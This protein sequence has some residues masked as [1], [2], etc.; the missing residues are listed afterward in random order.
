MKKTFLSIVLAAAWLGAA[1]AEVPAPSTTICGIMVSNDEW[2]S[3]ARAGVYSVEVRP[4]GAVKPV[5]T[6]AQMAQVAAAVR[7][8]NLM[9]CVE[10][11]A[12]GTFY[13]SKYS[14]NSWN[15]NG[16][17]QEIDVVNVPSD[18]CFDPVTGRA[19]GGFWDA[20]YLGYSRFGSF[21]LITA[22][23]TDINEVQRDERDIFA[24]AADGRGTIYCLFGAYDYLATLD[25]KT[26][27]VE[28]IKTTGLKPETRLSE[29]RL[30]S[31]CYDAENDRL[32]AVV[33][34]A[35]HNVYTSALYTIDPHT[36]EVTKVMDMPGNACMAGIYVLEGAVPAEAPAEPTGLRVEPTAGLNGRV[37]FTAPT[38]TVG[39]SELSGT[40]M[41]IVSVNGAE[42][43]IE[44]IAPGQEVSRELT[45]AEG[46]N[47]VKVTM[48]SDVQRGGSATVKAWIGEDT[49]AGVRDLSLTVADGR[50]TLTWKA[51]LTGVHGAALDPAA[52]RYRIVRNSDGAVVAESFPGLSF[53]DTSVPAGTKALS[54]TVTAFNSKGESEPVRSNTALASGALSVPFSE[55][56]DTEDDFGLWTVRDLNGGATWF[57][58]PGDNIVPDPCATYK[59]DSDKLPADEWL[60]SPAIQLKAGETYRLGYDWRVYNSRYKE[61]FS[62]A[63][64][65][66]PTPESMTRILSAQEN[67]TNVKFESAA[68]AFTVETD[69]IYYLGIHETSAAYQ[70]QLYLDNV[71]ISAMDAGVPAAIADLKAEPA[72]QGARR[73]TLGFTAPDKT[74]K[75][76]PLSGSLTYSV[77]RDGVAVAT[78]VSVQPGQPVSLTDEAIEKDGPVSYTAWCENESGAG[79]AVTV[80][81]YCGVDAPGAVTG[82]TLTEMN[83]HPHL[84]W[85]EP[86]A[87]ANN[88]WFDRSQLT[89]RIVRSDGT[90]VAEK[91]VG[92]SYTDESFTSPASGQEG[93]WYL[94][95]PYCGSTKGVYAQTELMLFGQPYK[96][97]VTE[98]FA[99]AS[100]ALNPWSAQS[101]TAVNYSWT[102]DNM[103][104]NPQAPDQNG[105]RGLAT[106]HSVGEPVGSTAYFYSPM[107]DISALDAPEVSF[108]LYHAPGEGNET[109]DFLVSAGTDA[110]VQLED[111]PTVR[112]D[113]ESGWVR[114]AFDLSA[115]KSAPW[116]RIGFM[117]TADKKADFYLD[118]FAIAEAVATDAALTSLSGPARIAAGETARY[119][120]VVL[121]AGRRE[122]P[123]VKISLTDAAGTELAHA[124]TGAIPAG[125]EARLTLEVPA[126]ETGTLNVTASVSAE[127]DANPA[128]DRASCVTQVVTPAVAA[129]TDVAAIR[130]DDG[131]EITWADV[132]A[133]GVVTDDVES[134][135]PWAIDGIGEWS[136]WDGDYDLTYQINFQG[137][138]YPHATD[139]KAFQVCD[140]REMGITIWPE[141]EPHSGDNM[142]MAMCSQIYVNND[143]L[144]SPELNGR[145]Q[146]ISFFARSFTLQDTPAERMRVWYSTTDNDPANFTEITANY[147]ELP[148]NWTEYRYF[149]PEGARH[150]AVNCVSD[151]AFAMFVDD[152]TF[153]DLSVP[154][155]ELTGYEV[156]RDGQRIGS[157]DG[158]SF[159]DTEAPAEAASY[160]VKAVYDRGE[161]AMSEAA[162]VEADAI[163]DLIA[164]DARVYVA[165]G[166]IHIIGAAGLPVAVYSAQGVTVFAADRASD[167]EHV[168]AATGVYVVKVGSRAVKVSLY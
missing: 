5:K 113:A 52:L 142:F 28:R 93:L 120:A 151:G 56:W 104:Y 156:Y 157:A 53:T 23:A 64:G 68:T 66:E 167:A 74:P 115:Y 106:Y 137:F 116:I 67:V 26:G 117:G 90:V 114:Y 59:Y 62:F 143:W 111:A 34:E 145:E 46:E 148:A 50:P 24:I 102:L 149:V 55:G 124:S 89:Y 133:R 98:T 129:P 134:Y 91:A 92:T 81:S 127:G 21:D 100:M 20:D 58:H 73:V 165:D 83:R 78:G 25:P 150:F 1:A 12:D 39:G 159:T 18:L 135:T 141:G 11:H 84:S 118:N 164:A 97:P 33:A 69:G 138:Q 22:E 166:Y 107:I 160:T 61:S 31:M 132:T 41:A 45:M 125:R 30:S 82:L 79:V 108:W 13:Y 87:G 110:F 16:T 112:R 70:W 162:R 54:Y 94:V 72:A 17:R 152:L 9:Y 8:D 15:I 147:I 71:S 29:R 86:A 85:E 49:P 95:T 168:P 75:G 60:V 122:L 48:A 32:I 103:G 109:M 4:D 80:K 130:T 51:P 3:D 101:S 99:D 144:I 153:N 96:A 14:T 158:T 37:C 42:T 10:A 123:D 163:G 44:G 119:N 128:N 7:K 121:N 140:A 131:V 76:N 155:W 65:A 139:R 19:Y 38:K 105:D 2:A 47:T 40:M 161:S 77:T 35:D 146:W 154:S 136:M 36:A 27:Q 6:N 63:L 57:R 126:T 88:G 43:V